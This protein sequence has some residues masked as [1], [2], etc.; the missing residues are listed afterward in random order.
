[1]EHQKQS[2]GSTLVPPASTLPNTIKKH[3]T[4]LFD[5]SLRLKSLENIAPCILKCLNNYCDMD[6]VPKRNVKK[7]AD[8]D[9]QFICF[10][11][12]NMKDCS[13]SNL[14]YVDVEDAIDNFDTWV[15]DWDSGLNEEEKL[16]VQDKSW[17]RGLVFFN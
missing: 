1:L 6:S 8:R 5:S 12:G 9:S 13:S 4:M 16:L 3:P 7:W 11:N 2:A 10:L 17:R 14:C 15:T